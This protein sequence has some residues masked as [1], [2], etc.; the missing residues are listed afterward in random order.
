MLAELVDVPVLQAVEQ[1]IDMR[2]PVNGRWVNGTGGDV[3]YNKKSTTSVPSQS[4]EREEHQNNCAGELLAIHETIERL[5]QVHRS[6][7]A[8]VRRAADEFRRSSRTPSNSA[9][10]LES[11]SL[12]FSGKNV[13]ILKTISMIDEMVTLPKGE[14]GENDEK[15]TYCIKSFDQAEDDDQEVIPSMPQERIQDRIVEEIPDV[16]IPQVMEETIGVVKHVPQDRVQS[17]AV[18]QI[19]AEPVPRIQE[20]TGQVNQLV[21]QDRIA[22]RSS[23]HTI[24][25]PNPQIQ[26]KLVDV[27]QLILQE[28]ISER[29]GATLALRIQETLSEV[30]QLIR[31]ERISERIVE[32]FMDAPVPQIPERPVEENTEETSQNQSLEENTLHPS[33]EQCARS[34][35]VTWV[36]QASNSETYVGSCSVSNVARVARILTGKCPVSMYQDEDETNKAKVEAKNGLED[37]CVTLRN[38]AIEGQRG[39]KCEAGDKEKTEDAVQHACDWLDNNMLA[40]NDEFEAHQKELEGTV[41]LIDV[42]AAAQHQVPAIQRVQRTVEVPK[43]EFID[44]VMDVPGVPNIQSTQK[45]VEVPRV[46]FIDR[47]VD[48][49][50]VMQREAFQH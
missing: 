46:Q 3:E 47:V 27:I 38:A 49:P 43:V 20:E 9:I 17:N 19:V 41:R 24:D 16:S 36:R 40:E 50:A 7:V 2:M 13:E 45:T 25:I 4:M 44:K 14:Q 35:A 1:K 10:D 48:D 18:E 30:I 37:C 34:S 33:S 21:P 28:R 15:M 42:P 5:M 32:T 11:I 23:E 12:T 29:I 26:G 8:V 22:D 31:Q 6:T 39:F